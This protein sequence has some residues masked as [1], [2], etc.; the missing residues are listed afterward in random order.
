MKTTLATVLLSATCLLGLSGCGG[1]IKVQ[2][3]VE[4]KGYEVEKVG[5]R[6]DGSGRTLTVYVE[7]DLDATQK[8]DVQDTAKAAYTKEA[9]TV[10]VKK[11]TGSSGGGGSKAN[12]GGSKPNSSKS[13]SNGGARE[14]R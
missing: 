6:S 3:A 7:Q 5:M 10:E 12:T 14:N 4:A 1:L 8:Q 2:R 11:A 13:N 9:K